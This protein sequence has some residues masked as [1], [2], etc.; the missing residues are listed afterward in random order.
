MLDFLP[1][2]RFGKGQQGSEGAD[3]DQGEVRKSQLGSSAFLVPRQA[4]LGAE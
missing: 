3:N 4:R 2:S 1:L